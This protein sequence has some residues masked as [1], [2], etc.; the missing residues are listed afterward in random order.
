MYTNDNCPPLKIYYKMYYVYV[1]NVISLKNGK[2]CTQ[3]LNVANLVEYSL[4][5][6]STTFDDTL[7]PTSLVAVQ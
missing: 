4:H 6:T 2:I 1:N 5:C 3:N 7:L